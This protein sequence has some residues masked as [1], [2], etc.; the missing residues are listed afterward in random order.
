MAGSPPGGRAVPAADEAVETP[1]ASL[2]RTRTGIAFGLAAA[3]I[4]GGFLSVSGHGI[5]VGLQGTD[6]A[7]VRC[8]S[9]GVILAPWLLLHSPLTLAGLGWPRGLTLTLLVGPLFIIVG[10]SGYRFAPVAHGAV[11]QPGMLTLA[12]TALAALIL[13]ERPRPR[14]LVGI[15][16]LIGGLAT[17]AGPGLVSA[18]LQAWRGDLMFAAAGTMFAGFTVLLRRWRLDALAATAVVSVVSA[19]LYTPVYLLSVGMGR[20][21]SAPAAILLEQ[22]LVQGILSGIL[23]LFAFG[24]AVTLLGAGPAALFP[25]LTPVVAVLIGIALVGEVPTW[26]QGAGLLLATVGLVTALGRRTA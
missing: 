4:W 25:A 11:I 6:L 21:T 15:A 10:A 5:A 22:V 2:R 13:G 16:I 12:G 19:A 24:R 17:I 14:N 18:S 1:A 3:V 20:L 8:A 7:F 9:A 23:A 26:S